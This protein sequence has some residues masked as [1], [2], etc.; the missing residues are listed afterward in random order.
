MSRRF[1]IPASSSKQMYHGRKKNSAY[2]YLSRFQ[3]YVWPSLV[4]WGIDRLIRLIRLIV[5]NFMH[6]GSE[7]IDAKCEL[8]SEH[9]VRLTLKR[10]P[11]FHWAPGQTAYIITPGVSTLP[12]EAHPFTI[13]SYDSSTDA[14]PLPSSTSSSE[15][16]LDVKGN[17]Y[18]KEVVF[19]VNVRG[20]FTRRLADTAARHGTIKAYLDGPYGLSPDLNRFDTSIF[21]AGNLL[22]HCNRSIN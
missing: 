19:L 20:G 8:V 5:F 1:T 10:P 22:L 9:F 4:I 21:I 7:S 18:W 3:N 15:E 6:T 17:D 2:L 14:A 11:H 12:F 13:A 16:K